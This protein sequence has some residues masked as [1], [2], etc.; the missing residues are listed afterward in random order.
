MFLNTRLL[1]YFLTSLTT[2]L[3][4]FGATVESA[5]QPVDLDLLS[6]KTSSGDCP[7]GYYG[8][9][10][11]SKCKAFCSLC[12]TTGVCL[13]CSKPG[14]TLPGCTTACDSGWYGQ[15]CKRR[16]DSLCLNQE[17]DS[18][19]GHCLACREEGYMLPDCSTPCLPGTFGSHCQAQCPATCPES[20]DRLSGTCTA[21]KVGDGPHCT[22]NCATAEHQESCEQH[23]PDK[24][25][26]WCNTTHRSC[27]M[28]WPGLKAPDCREHCDPG[29]FGS[30]CSQDCPSRCRDQTCDAVTG[31]CADCRDG[32]VG[33]WCNGR[34]VPG[35][36][37]PGCALTCPD[38]CEDNLCQAETGDCEKC[39]IG[40]T[41]PLCDRLC[42]SGVF[43]VKCSTACPP[44]CR[45]PCDPITGECQDCLAGYRGRTCNS[46]CAEGSYGLSCNRTCPVGCLGDICHHETGDCAECKGYFLGTKCDVF[47]SES[48][49]PL[50]IVVY[51]VLSL[52]APIV[53]LGI[54]MVCYKSRRKSEN[55]SILAAVVEADGQY[56]SKM[57]KRR[58]QRSRISK[59]EIQVVPETAKTVTLN[60]PREP[61]GDN[62]PSASAVAHLSLGNAAPPDPAPMVRH[63]AEEH[64]KS[65]GK[66]VPDPLL[67]ST[68][69]S[70]MQRLSAL[71]TGDHR[72]FAFS[73]GPAFGKRAMQETGAANNS[74]PVHTSYDSSHHLNIVHSPSREPTRSE[75]S[76]TIEC[77]Q[78]KSP[79]LAV[80]ADSYI[81]VETQERQTFTSGS[82]TASFEE[83]APDQDHTKRRKNIVHIKLP[84]VTKSIGTSGVFA[85]V[86]ES[87]VSQRPDRTVSGNQFGPAAKAHAQA[88]VRG[89][90]QNEQIKKWIQAVS[91][92]SNPE[93]PDRVLSPDQPTRQTSGLGPTNRSAQTTRSAEPSRAPSSSSQAKKSKPQR[94]FS[95]PSQLNIIAESWT[96][97][98]HTHSQYQMTPPTATHSRQQ[99]SSPTHSR[100]QVSSPTHFRYQ[101]SPTTQHKP[102]THSQY[103]MSPPP[104]PP[105]PVIP[106]NMP[107]SLHTMSPSPQNL[108][109]PQ[110]RSSPPRTFL[111]VHGHVSPQ[112]ANSQ[113]CSE[114]QL[115]QARSRTQSTSSLQPHNTLSSL[116]T[117]P[118]V[119][120]SYRTRSN[121]YPQGKSSTLTNVTYTD[122]SGTGYARKSISSEAQD[123][124]TTEVNTRAAGKSA[125]SEN[126]S[127][128]MES[129]DPSLEL[130]L[131]AAENLQHSQPLNTGQSNVF[132][133]TSAPACHSKHREKLRRAEERLAS[134][135]RQLETVESSG[136][137]EITS[138]VPAGYNDTGHGY[139]ESRNF[140]WLKAKHGQAEEIHESHGNRIW[141]EEERSDLRTQ[142]IPSDSRAA[143]FSWLAPSEDA[144]SSSV[145][146]SL[147]TRSSD[148]ER[149]ARIRGEPSEES[150]RQKRPQSKSP[151]LV[152]CATTRQQVQTASPERKAEQRLDPLPTPPAQGKAILKPVHRDRSRSRSRPASPDLQE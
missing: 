54:V 119:S 142:G 13:E 85:K 10:C 46:T 81:T 20:C 113:P 118:T 31:E 62:P 114:L 135:A 43:G 82:Q 104:P 56:S 123:I 30:Q 19:T 70:D 5:S 111:K 87:S 77:E 94:V 59:N 96:S 33:R 61:R 128:S 76:N 95:S 41:G 6:N 48:T 63:P 50:E 134:T 116:Y 143:N 2:W 66:T 107:Q 68:F 8:P 117:M 45:W 53:L 60:A 130:R 52:L 78:N 21:C 35:L 80:S 115:Q 14:V 44:K 73:D 108:P 74:R 71:P 126:Q 139:R 9:Q 151:G 22:V 29:T 7:R 72:A 23:C 92:E 140:I 1:I 148:V 67:S 90:G 141:H 101:V 97:Q 131:S 144:S 32:Y 152:R 34:C 64:K 55:Q 136:V 26:G 83:A 51:S 4:Y 89:M 127:R 103:Q 17:C 15:S 3:V 149:P 18:N 122:M 110:L 120:D 75:K 39:V 129:T 93:L 145:L 102:Q 57:A 137:D 105:P 88:A 147:Q 11:L 125:D 112:H 79:K 42:D 124:R 16:C 65:R 146:D 98:P 58:V 49:Q 40:Y 24:C 121:L 27:G 84:K 25:V 69:P 138:R 12:D 91:A 36:Y 47:V 100:Q 106:Q 86:E 28:C 38:T 99:V 109:E 37:G 133:N 132:N 150:S